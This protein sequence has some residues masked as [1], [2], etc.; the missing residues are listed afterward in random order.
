MLILFFNAFFQN[1][2]QV[3]VASV[4][5]QWWFQPDSISPCCTSAVMKPLWRCMTTSFASICLGSLVTLPAQACHAVAGLFCLRLT[6]SKEGCWSLGGAFAQILRSCNR[7]GFT[8]VGLYGYSFNEGGSKALELFETRE[9]MSVV[10][11]DLIPNVLLMASVVIGGST[12]IFGVL[13]EEVDGY[14]FTSLHKPIITAFLLG[15]IEGFV[16]SNIMLLGVVGSAVNTILVC[17]AAGPFEF[18]KN[19][20]QLSR[21]MRDMWSQQVWETDA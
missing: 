1:I 19:H 21:E 13:V 5:G 10:N 7:W 17:F 12:G 6:A 3:T 9:W 16:L 20:P 18:D 4:V 14:T 11:D 2:V 8:Y 15:G